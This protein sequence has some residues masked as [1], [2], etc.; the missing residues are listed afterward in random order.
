M[1]K[2]FSTKFSE[3]VLTFGHDHSARSQGKRFSRTLFVSIGFCWKL[4][5]YFSLNI[6]IKLEGSVTYG[7]VDFFCLF[8][9][10]VEFFLLIEI[11]SAVGEMPQI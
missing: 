3:Y 4:W 1:K 10:P 2:E 11:T 5:N 7:I 6:E 9:V 8:N